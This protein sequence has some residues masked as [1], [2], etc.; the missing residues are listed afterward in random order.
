VPKTA[1]GWSSATKTPKLTEVLRLRYLHGLSSGDFVPA[2]GQFPGSGAGLSALA[3]TKLTQQ[4]AFNERDL[5]DVDY[6]AVSPEPTVS[7]C[8]MPSTGNGAVRSC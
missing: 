6:G 8:R 2:L 4:R 5:S 7:L 1:V 3:V